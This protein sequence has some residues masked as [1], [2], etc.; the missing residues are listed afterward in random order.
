MLNP[1]PT[2]L[3]SGHR[4]RG[5]PTVGLAALAALACVGPL[6]PQT[7][8][9]EDPR[10]ANAWFSAG[11]SSVAEAARFVKGERPA[12]NVILFVG[13]GM[14]VS[15]VTA[16]RILE[17]Q[18][19]GDT[20]E[21]NQLAF[22]AL[23][24]VALSKTYNVDA[25]V[26]D[27]ASTMTA[28]V[29]GVK[30]VT[31]VLGVD[32][33]I[34]RGD[35]TSVEGSRVVTI[36]EEAERRGLATGVVS[37]ARITH[38]TPAG[39]YAHAPFRFWEDDSRMTEA[40]RADRFPDIARQLVEFPVGD[41][42][43]VALGG[44][45]RHFKPEGEA[46]PEDPER[47]GRR[48]DGRD[49]TAEWVAAREG[50][51]YVWNR[52]QLAGIDRDR[53][54]H[55][56]GL[57]EPSD[58]NWETDRASDEAG[59]PS[60]AEMTEVAIDLLARDPDGFFLMVEGGRIDHGHHAGNAHRALVDTIAMSDAVRVAMEKT[61]AED[62]LI[63]VTAD[64]SHTLTI[65]GYPK[66]GN[67][68]LGK[69]VG[70]N[71]YAEGEDAPGLDAMG[72]PYTTLSYA[73]GP[74]YTGASGQQPEGPHTWGH[75][76]CEPSSPDCSFEG[77]HEGRPDLS[78]IDTEDPSFLQEATVPMRSETHA[79][80]DVPIYA[81]GARAA[82]FHGVREQSYIYHAMVEALGW[83]SGGVPTD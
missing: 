50:A 40:A 53:T 74:G 78:E 10:E 37:T 43:E 69:V 33:S 67:P 27:S 17:G 29:A 75:R 54:R 66:R 59:E 44:G 64:H 20:G 72:L 16:A 61:S 81:G 68:I 71:W 30:T 12:R 14:G 11:R 25:Q 56:L 3:H 38:A 83:T 58:M 6:A 62:T 49:L 1:V 52:D 31:G 65:S 63:V 4:Q 39:C 18:R 73:N 15:T 32:E 48:L 24:H 22:D 28:M 34:R 47:P 7:P 55:L 57:F 41:G 19:R 5:F 21:E 46:D 26:S 79:G 82:L 76:P 35:H 13:D 45:R 70:V 8:R 60:L 2:R 42:I 51:V 9:A 23:P 36:L 77:I 80:E